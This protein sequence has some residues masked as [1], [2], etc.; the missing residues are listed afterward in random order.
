MDVF[1][2]IPFHCYETDGQTFDNIG[3]CRWPRGTSRTV[4]QDS[5]KNGARH[6]ACA[7]CWRAEDQG[8]VS[9]RQ[10][11]NSTMDWLLNKDIEKIAEDAV[12]GNTTT[13]MLKLY[14]SNLC[15]GLCVTCGPEASTAWQFTEG[16]P[17]KYM[18]Q[19]INDVGIDWDNIAYL[20]MVGGEPML[21][22]QNWR[23]LHKLALSGRTDLFV[24]MVTNASVKL[25]QD[26]ENLLKQFTNLNL[27]IS[28]DGIGS[29]YEYMRYPVKWVDFSDNIA[30]YK[31]ITSNI[32]AS[33]MISNLNIRYIDRT[34]NWLDNNDIPYLAKSIHE[35]DYYRPV[36]MTTDM[37]A[38]VLNTNPVHAI[39]YLD[40]SA[41]SIPHSSILEHAKQDIVRQ[42]HLKGIKI[43]DYLPG[44][45]DY[46]K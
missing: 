34:L 42:D 9:E 1:C 24:T 25:N 14:T 26:Q 31:Q 22:K 32:S 13:Y 28:M 39:H 8:A 40:Y 11:H 16:L 27:C 17:V 4:V 30:Y 43:E 12:N 29:V 5:I 23:V 7:T 38:E 2:V 6:P 19:D 37:Y 36:V 21:E 15:N 46:F 20:S 35:P 3:C 18:T 33:V 10:T 41:D 44:W 45:A